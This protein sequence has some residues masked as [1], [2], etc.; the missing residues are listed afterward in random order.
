[1][2]APGV[3]LAA[4]ARGF[5]VAAARGWTPADPAAAF[6]LSLPAAARVGRPAPSRLALRRCGRAFGR[7]ARTSR[8]RPEGESLEAM[9]RF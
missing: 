5:A 2:F 7:P 4:P 9:A 6:A 3:A 1:V 8:S